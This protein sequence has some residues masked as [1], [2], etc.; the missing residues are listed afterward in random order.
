MSTDAGFDRDRFRAHLRTRHLGHELIARH[1]VESTNDVAW[2]AM[3]QGAVDGVVVV[4]DVQTNG[5]GRQGRIWQTPSDKGLA[6]SVALHPG[7][8][9][10][11]LAAVPLAAGLALVRAL[12]PLGADGRLKWP[13]DVLLAGGKVSGILCESKR[14]PLGEDVVIVGVG[15][16]VGQEAADFAADI[17]ETATS[18]HMQGIEADRESVAAAWLNA[19][20]PL[21]IELEKAGAEGVL[22]A[23]QRSAAFWGDTLTVRTP[24]G[25]VTGVARELTADGGLV[26]E[27][28]DGKRTAVLAG[29]VEVGS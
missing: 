21:W 11:A 4:A 16:N 2:D 18:L 20:E 13:N 19:F 7:C 17:R 8:D 5:R 26:I 10:R 9:A 22:E 27:T 15:V 1:V 3:A 6:L 29:D 14:T 12:E 24:A 25:E 23:W 28:P